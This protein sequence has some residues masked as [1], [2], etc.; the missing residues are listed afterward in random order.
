MYRQA[1]DAHSE[2]LNNEA[3]FEMKYV[4]KN[5]IEHLFKPCKITIQ[6]YINSILM[7]LQFI[8]YNLFA[9]RLSALYD[10]RRLLKYSISFLLIEGTNL[11]IA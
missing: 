3:C 2:R 8:I 9:R 1:N 5:N 10:D 7:K 6:K 4:Y 11:E